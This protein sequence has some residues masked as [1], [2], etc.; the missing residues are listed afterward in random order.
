M[1]WI[2]NWYRNNKYPF[3]K[4]FLESVYGLKLQQMLIGRYYHISCNFKDMNKYQLY[5]LAGQRHLVRELLTN[6]TL[7]H[8][9][10]RQLDVEA[11]YIELR[12]ERGKKFANQLNDYVLTKEFRPAP[13]SLKLAFFEGQRNI[14]KDLWNISMLDIK[15]D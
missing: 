12:S 10:Q 14:A 6:N 5:Y 11:V 1:K 9:G 2:L 8:D 7:I 4:E 13:F 3:I 15:E